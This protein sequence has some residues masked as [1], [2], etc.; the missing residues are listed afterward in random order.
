M[1]E[2]SRADVVAVAQWG[3]G[4][5]GQIHYRQSRPIDG[6]GHPHKLPLYTDCSGFVTLCYN[7][8][9]A[10]DPNGL[11]YNGYGYTGTLLNHL[12]H[13]P[14]GQVGPGDLVVFGSGSGHHVVIISG[15]GSDPEVVSHGQE[16]GPKALR[17]SAE[18]QAVGGPATFLR[19]KSLGIVGL[20]EEEGIVAQVEIAHDL[21]Q[22]T[23]PP[24]E[25]A[26]DSEETD[27]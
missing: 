20:Q 1:E 27:Q 8:A 12:A 11:G 22:A 17:L 6:I 26:A 25:E 2:S 9:R 7:W 19:S 13:I 4:H 23:N 10:P 15:S 14:R 16:N 5:E 24:A 3:V 18:L 21:S